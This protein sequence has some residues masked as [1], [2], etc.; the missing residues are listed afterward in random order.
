MCKQHTAQKSALKGIERDG[1]SAGK[2]V[3]VE[4]HTYR[5]TNVYVTTDSSF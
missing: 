1:P 3:S 5:K 2:A 4:L